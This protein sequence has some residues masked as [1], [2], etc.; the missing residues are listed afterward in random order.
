[1]AIRN[2]L[3]APRP[4]S[5]QSRPPRLPCLAGRGGGQGS[6]ARLES[7]PPAPAAMPGGPG[8]RAGLEAVAQS[9]QPPTQSTAQC[10][11]NL[12]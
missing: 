12:G 8:G 9:P 1:M 6:P 11:G 4:A 2:S 7:E 3:R 5:N 10:E